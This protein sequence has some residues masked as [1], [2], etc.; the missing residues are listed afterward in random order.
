MRIKKDNEI[1]VDIIIVVK[2]DWVSF[3]SSDAPKV[4]VDDMIEDMI[5]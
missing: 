1:A 4:R 5:W 3:S 2:F